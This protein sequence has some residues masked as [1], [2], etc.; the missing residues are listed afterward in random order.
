MSTKKLKTVS[1][2]TIID[3]HIGK[4]GSKRR[5]T[6]EYELKFELLGSAIKEARTH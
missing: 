2:D 5:D 6:F 1:L 4:V 3:K